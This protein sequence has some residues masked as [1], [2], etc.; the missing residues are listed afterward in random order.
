VIGTMDSAALHI[1]RYMYCALAGLGWEI[2]QREAAALRTHRYMYFALGR[3]EER[4]YP[5]FR[6][7]GDA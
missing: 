1:H 6:V 7:R 5:H 4:G 2:L 3:A